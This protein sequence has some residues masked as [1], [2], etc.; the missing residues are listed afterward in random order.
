MREKHENVI[1]PSTLTLLREFGEGFATGN[2]PDGK[3]MIDLYFTKSPKLF[4]QKGG[5]EGAFSQTHYTQ[6][7]AFDNFAYHMARVLDEASLVALTDRLLE[8][9]RKNLDGNTFLRNNCLAK[10]F[11]KLELELFKN[12]PEKR[13]AV[14]KHHLDKAGVRDQS[15]RKN[16]MV[17]LGG[18]EDLNVTLVGA[19]PLDQVGLTVDATKRNQLANVIQEAER[20]Q[21]ASLMQEAKRI[22]APVIAAGR[23]AAESHDALADSLSKELAQQ[24]YEQ[25]MPKS[26]RAALGLKKGGALSTTSAPASMMAVRSEIKD[27]KERAGEQSHVNREEIKDHLQALLKK[28]FQKNPALLE[29]YQRSSPEQ[30][31]AFKNGI[32]AQLKTARV[33]NGQSASQVVDAGVASAGPE[34]VR[35]ASKGQER[36][37]S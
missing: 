33:Q 37:R 12:N 22:A 21:L 28:S 20:T 9:E 13:N 5:A 36:S 10:S 25:I 1:L 35:K 8:E 24:A 4:A 11:L 31:L 29:Q 15:V 3:T 17:S 18:N 26:V 23:G 30:K 32:I 2:F 34:L 27:K 16:L 19:K 14:L 6:G 7:E